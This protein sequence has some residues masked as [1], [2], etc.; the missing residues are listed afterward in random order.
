MKFCTNCKYLTWV[1][2]GFAE[3]SKILMKFINGNTLITKKKR[4]KL[5]EEIHEMYVERENELERLR[6]AGEEYESKVLQQD[7]TPQVPKETV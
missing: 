3:Q 6:K 7:G 2:D 1:L 4:E 5:F